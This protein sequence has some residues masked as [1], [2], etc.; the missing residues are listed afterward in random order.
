MAYA[1]GNKIIS[2]AAWY[3]RHPTHPYEAIAGYIAIYPGKMVH[4]MS[5]EKKRRHKKGI[6]MEAGLRAK[7]WG[8]L[9]VGWGR[10]GGSEIRLTPSHDRREFRNSLAGHASQGE[11]LG[12]D[13]DTANEHEVPELT[14]FPWTSKMVN[15]DEPSQSNAHMT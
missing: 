8:H 14:D 4:V 3:Y 10:L 5:I 6:F 2:Q 12:I 11:V 7:L 9:R 13:L 1:V 15:V